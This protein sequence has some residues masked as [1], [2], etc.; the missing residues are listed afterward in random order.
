MAKIQLGLGASFEKSGTWWPFL[1]TTMALASENSSKAIFQDGAGNRVVMFGN[2]LDA[3]DEGDVA[4]TVDHVI[5]QNDKGQ[6]ILDAEGISV[7][8]EALYF[9]ALGEFLAVTE[10]VRLVSTKD[11][12]ILGTNFSDELMVG[13]DGGDDLVKGF[14]GDDFFRASGGDNTLIAGNGHD[15]LAYHFSWSGGLPKR[16]ANVDN[17]AGSAINPWGGRDEISGFEVFR[18]SQKDDVYAGNGGNE[19]F[20]TLGGNDKVDGRGGRDTIDYDFDNN[21]GGEDGIVANLVTGKV[22]DGY[23]YTDTVKNIEAIIGTEYA[24]SFVGSDKGDEFTGLSGNDTFRGGQGADMFL[25]ATGFEKDK[26]SDFDTSGKDHDT[27]VLDGF[28]GINRYTD[29]KDHFEKKGSA[30]EI[31]LGNGDVLILE[32]VVP[33]E[34]NKTLFDFS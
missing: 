2:N 27:I 8:Y 1:F 5:I 24:D 6:L 17:A 26:I 29:L 3:S 9:A 25:F 20:R 11:D 18:G 33:G 34:L 4:G 31:T 28:E 14:G 16:G 32:G 7:K 30:V 19:T 12:T 15:E 10:V 13:E 22:I 23:G 21:Y